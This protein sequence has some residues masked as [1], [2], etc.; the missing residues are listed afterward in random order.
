MAQTA[1]KLTRRRLLTICVATTA[2]ALWPE[3]GGAL[4][5]RSTVQRHRR[6][7]ALGAEASVILYHKDPAESERLSV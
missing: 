3:P 1:A 4:G 5:N 7:T 6:G 2:L